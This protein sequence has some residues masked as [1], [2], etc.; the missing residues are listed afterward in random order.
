MNQESDAKLPRSNDEIRAMATEVAGALQAVTSSSSVA[1]G[2][3]SRN[4]GV[5]E[6]LRMRFIAVRSALFQRGV[7]DPVLI[8]FDTATGTQASTAEIVEQLKAVAASL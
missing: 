4:R 3:G 8:R 2:G 1:S 6:E 7:F 5:P